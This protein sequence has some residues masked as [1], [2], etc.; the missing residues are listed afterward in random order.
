M[1][2]SII[3]YEKEYY[4]INFEKQVYTINEYQNLEE[5]G[6]IGDIHFAQI[7]TKYGKYDV[8]LEKIKGP[9][10][11]IYNINIKINNI[12]DFQE[13]LDKLIEK[14]KEQGLEIEKSNQS[15]SVYITLLKD[16]SECL[17]HRISCHKRKTYGEFGN[18]SYDYFKETILDN[19]E[20]IKEY[21]EKNYLNITEEELKE[22][23]TI[24]IYN[25]RT[26]KIE[27]FIQEKEDLEKI[28]KYLFEK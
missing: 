9:E 17:E 22:M 13:E 26:E 10:E 4:W 19:I 20:E 28:K 3:D 27:K 23:F 24:S 21:L 7:K 6:E 14:L 25:S 12:I 8:E 2:L 1:R 15:E 5:V 11:D 16:E 18:Y